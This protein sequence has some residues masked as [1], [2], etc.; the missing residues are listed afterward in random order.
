M[1]ISLVP[2]L[3]CGIMRYLRFKSESLAPDR[4]F[5]LCVVANAHC[6][7]LPH[8]FH[9]CLLRRKNILSFHCDDRRY[10]LCDTVPF[11]PTLSGLWRPLAAIAL[12]CLIRAGV[13]TFLSD[14]CRSD[15]LLYQRTKPFYLYTMEMSILLPSRLFLEFSSLRRKSSIWSL[16]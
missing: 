1:I 11:I 8:S 16:R 2:M 10:G 7:L 5:S 3:P 13:R 4:S 6:G 14:F 9:P 15:H 12:P